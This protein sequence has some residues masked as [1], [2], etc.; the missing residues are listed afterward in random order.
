MVGSVD[1]AK[2]VGAA[3]IVGVCVALALPAVAAENYQSGTMV[4]ITSGANGLLVRLDTGAPTNCAGTPYGWMLI[5]ESNK[6]ML[7]VAL[8]AW[9]A[10][11]RQVT[12]YT[13][14]IVP[15]NYCEINQFDPA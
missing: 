5:R 14:P 11:N 2:R 13:S 3:A 1:L 6:T 10:G 15:G 7:S 9:Y 8:L 4:D 12:V